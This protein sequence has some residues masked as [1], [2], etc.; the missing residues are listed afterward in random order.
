MSTSPAPAPTVL[1]HSPVRVV[2]GAGTLAQLGGLA[3]D[4]GA[5][6]VLLVTDPGIRRAG[7]VERAAESLRCAG[8]DAGVFDAVAENPTT[9]HVAAGLAVARRER[10]DFL[11]GLG[12]GS[13]LDCTKGINLL[14]TNGGEIKDYWGEGK[15]SGPMLPTIAIPT[16]AGTGSEGQSFALISDPVTHQKMACG[17]RRAPRA[18]GLRP[19]VAIL[20]EEL[21]AT[22][23]ARVA[24]AAGIDALA[25][26]VET[27]GTTRRSPV[28]LEFTRAAWERIRGALPAVL[29]DPSDAAARRDMLLGAHLAG[30]AIENSML[31]AAHACANPL[32]ARYGTVHGV[33][34]GV[35]LPHVVRF[36]A[37]EGENP[38]AALA[39]PA[40]ELADRCA[41]MLAVAG[42]APRLRDH[43]VAEADIPGLAAAAAKQWTAKFNPRRLAEAELTSIYAAAW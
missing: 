3:R 27:A 10:V 18:G 6:R 21:T 29:R 40:G 5:R 15:P 33:A 1:Q 13:A 11:I 41:E 8:V 38:Y 30:C 37:A 19:R 26:V 31:G 34:V 25:H 16:T 24:A 20:D 9:A 22:Q 35:L 12:G 2:A 4:E 39:L 43:G 7:H 28:S 23:P 14:L 42:V 36:N 32:T 17:D